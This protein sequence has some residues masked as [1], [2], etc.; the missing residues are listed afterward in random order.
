MRPAAMAVRS[1][2][3]LFELNIEG[4]CANSS[5]AKGRA[6]RAN[7]TLQDRLVKELRVQGSSTIGDAHAYAPAFIADYNRHFAKPPRNNFDAHRRLRDDEDLEL[8]FTWR[9]PRKVSHV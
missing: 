4:I 3:A 2:G 9:E 8:I 5:Q 7:L 1:S 6:E